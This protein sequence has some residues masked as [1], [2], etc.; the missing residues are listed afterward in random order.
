MVAPSRS[1]IMP[2]Y[3]VRTIDEHDLVGIFVAPDMLRLAL[4]VDECVDPGVCECQR[5]KP[6][7]IMWT[8]PAVVVPI[9]LSDD[10]EDDAVEVPWAQLSVTERWWDSLYGYTNGKWRPLVFDL[11]DLYGDPEEPED[12]PPKGPR[13]GVLA[14]YHIGSGALES[15]L[16]P[17]RLPPCPL[18]RPRTGAAGNSR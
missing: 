5:M 11:D 10:D 13:A 16:F 17:L 8:S 12:P 1:A 14:F 18:R 9:A 15:S 6:R 2:T 4:L 7:G 3:L